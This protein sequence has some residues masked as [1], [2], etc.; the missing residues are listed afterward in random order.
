MANTPRLQSVRDLI[1][2][3]QMLDPTGDRLVVVRWVRGDDVVGSCELHAESYNA[4]QKDSYQTAEGD[5]RVLRLTFY[6]E[7]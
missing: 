3:L 4:T 6:E 7:G 1:A 5:R 2:T